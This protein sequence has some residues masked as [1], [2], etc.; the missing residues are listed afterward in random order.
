MKD[1]Q[2]KST[3]PGAKLLNTNQCMAKPVR[4]QRP[5]DNTDGG[6]PHWPIGTMPVGGFRSV[7]CFD[8]NQTST[9]LSPTTKPGRKV[10]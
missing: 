2:I 3:V 1:L 5:A 10:Y 8:E 7:F 9:K 4:A 6:Q